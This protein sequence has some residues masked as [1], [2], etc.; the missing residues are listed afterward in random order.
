[1]GSPTIRGIRLA[2]PIRPMCGAQ[3]GYPE[4]AEGRAKEIGPAA[5]LYAMGVILYGF[6]TGSPPFRGA[7]FLETLQ[8]VKTAEPVPPSRL[9]PGVPRDI[10]TI[11]LK[12]LQKD[13][14]KRYESALA[15]AEDLRRYQ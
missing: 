2:N 6:L 8:Q 12:C 1:M 14:G 9:V 5:D 7:T 13:S 4:Q 10:E 15:L 3:D 11:A